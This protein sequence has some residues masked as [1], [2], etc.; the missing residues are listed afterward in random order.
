MK[1]ILFT[2]AGCLCIASY[3]IFFS[4]TTPL[5]NVPSSGVTVVAFGDSLIV[6]VGA[7]EG[8][9][10]VSVLSRRLA[11]PVVNLGQSGDTTRDAL[12]RLDTVIK[13]NPKVVIL[14]LG[15]NDF[16]QQIPAAETFQNLEVIIETI[17]QS[18]SAVVLLG[19]RGGVLRDSYKSNFATLAKQ[20][21][22]AYVTN[23]LDGVI[24]DASLMSDLVHP[25]DAGYL[26]IADKV[27][28][29]LRKVLK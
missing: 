4:S 16:L 2:L 5:T 8:N 26:V 22:T 23:I 7:S 19:V 11:E 15:G 18:G 1:Y 9:D 25:N 24:T 6:G 29:V 21:N 13:Q 27:E 12:E 14:L 28:P 17:H 10:F 3:F 20:Q